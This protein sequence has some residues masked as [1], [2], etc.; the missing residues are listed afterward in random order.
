MKELQV[1]AIKDGSVIDHIASD[2][3]IKIMEM[4]N[5]DTDKYTVTL[6]FNLKS[7]ELGA[8]GIIKVEDKHLTEK[9]VEMV[10]LLSPSA[11]INHI[12]EYKVVRKQKV[13]P[14]DLVEELIKCSNNKCVTNFEGVATKFYREG[15]KYRCNYCERTIDK[16]DIVLK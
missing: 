1:S 9:E 10:Y 2:K 8:K 15:N 6:A 13:E 3:T 5:L 7:K 14:V 4:L 16:K 12:E 11:T